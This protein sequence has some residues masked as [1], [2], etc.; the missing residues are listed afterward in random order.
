M[1][2]RLDAPDVEVSIEI[3]HSTLY[4]KDLAPVPRARRTWRVGSFAALWISMSACIPTYMLAS[5]LIGGGMNWSQAIVTIFLGNLI[6]VVPMILNA[7]A[8]TRYGIPFPVFC[9]ASFGVR[10]ANVPAL[11]RAF[12]AC[13]WFGIQTWIGG[14]AI[15][16]IVGVFFPGLVRPDLPTFLGITFPAFICFL[17]FWG[18]NMLVVYKGIECIR[19]L[20]NIKAPLLI[21]L[22]LLLL[23]WAYRNAGGFGPILAQPSAFDEGQ[24]QA[25]KFW[26]FFVP[27]LTGMIGFWATLSLNIP[28]FS[29]YAHSQ[30]DQVIGQALGLPLTMALYSF[31]G[32]AVTSATTIIYGKTIWDPV[33]VLTHFQ[34]PVVLV[35]A[36][37]ALCLATLATNIAANVVSPANDFAHL[38]PRKISFRIGGLITGI[39][40][41]LMMPWKLVADPSGYIFTW[42]VGYSALLGPIGGIMIA[43]YFVLRHRRL[44]VDALYKHEGEFCYTNGFS[45]VALFSLIIAILPN[46]PGFLVTVKFIAANSIPQFFVT[47]YSYAWFVGFAIA[48][49]AYI[50]LRSLAP[51][52]P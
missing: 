35:V 10:G 11:M 21:A 14:A 26:T 23:W 46:L 27:S 3:E 16:K 38:A 32:V 12:V 49:G 6:V 19:W 33:D 37:F 25:G 20:L 44:N 2:T 4:N 40:G 31:I 29:R 42:L 43:D 17:F 34:N 24:A 48:F 50:A 22:G 39:V 36:M 1:S 8:G 18:I 41:V 28:D 7:H 9:R 15:Y 30:R 51:K 5:S 52:Q 45:I 13:G 47:L